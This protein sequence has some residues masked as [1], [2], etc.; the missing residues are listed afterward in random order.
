MI[1]YLNPPASLTLFKLICF[2]SVSPDA[3]PGRCFAQ[4]ISQTFFVIRS[5]KFPTFEFIS[6]KNYLPKRGKRWISL[7][8]YSQ[9]CGVGDEFESEGEG[10]SLGGVF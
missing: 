5:G 7:S 10:R 2:G 6:V 1:P 9:D 3:N 8:F 4:N